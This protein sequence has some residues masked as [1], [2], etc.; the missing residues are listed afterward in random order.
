LTEQLKTKIGK[1]SFSD[2]NKDAVL[3]PVTSLLGVSG[4]SREWRYLNKGTHDET[5]RAE[6]DRSAV[7]TIISCLEQI[8]SALT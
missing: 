8:D 6:F 4:E 1:N 3:D 7:E 2:P 5:N